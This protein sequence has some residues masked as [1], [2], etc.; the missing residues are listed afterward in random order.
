MVQCWTKHG[1]ILTRYKTPLG[2]YLFWGGGGVRHQRPHI[3][4]LPLDFWQVA[5]YEPMIPH[6]NPTCQ[7][8][9]MSSC[10]FLLLG[11]IQQP[12]KP[13]FVFCFFYLV[14][15]KRSAVEADQHLNLHLQLG[16]LCNLNSSRWQVFM[17]FVIWDNFTYCCEAA[18]AIN[19]HGTRMLSRYYNTGHLMGPLCVTVSLPYNIPRMLQVLFL[20]F[21]SIVAHK[22]LASLY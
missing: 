9:A 12:N 8:A 3:H 4:S 17:S 14:R 19:Q 22:K 7:P 15:C 11:V 6:L 10:Y 18:R 5:K 16:S 21:L 20:F 2:F 13:C 1:T